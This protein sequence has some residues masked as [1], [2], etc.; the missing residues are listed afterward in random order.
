[1]IRGRLTAYRR[2]IRSK[3]E[4][5]FVESHTP[6]EIAASFT[7]GTFVTA[8]PTLGAGLLL[9]VAVAYRF[10]RVSKLALFV[11]VVILNPVAKWG[12]Y[13][14]SFWVGSRPLGPA[15]SATLAGVWIPASRE[16]AVR[17]LV[18]NVVLAAGFAC[19]GYV[20]VHR[21]VREHRR[22]EI[23]LVEF[24]FDGPVEDR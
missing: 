4:A 12:V 6:H 2:R 17:L 22:R 16:I 23:D 10:D 1:M 8:L 15:G 3:F 18:G 20:V 7:V 21:L 13:A 19:V 24:V 5:A 9:F 14:A 11:P